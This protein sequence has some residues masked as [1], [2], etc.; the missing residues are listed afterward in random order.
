MKRKQSPTVKKKRCGFGG[1]GFK[2]SL[3][4]LL[5]RTSRIFSVDQKKEKMARA[6]ADGVLR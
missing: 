4:S 5:T 6:G 1:Q 2:G 3:L